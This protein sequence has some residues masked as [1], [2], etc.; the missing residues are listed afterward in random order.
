MTDK[1]ERA[2]ARRQRIKRQ[3]Q[4]SALT[5]L[6][7]LRMILGLSSA[8]L[9]RR[10]YEAYCKPRVLSRY[11]TARPPRWAN[12][13]AHAFYFVMNVQDTVE[14]RHFL[15]LLSGVTLP[16]QAPLLSLLTLNC[17]RE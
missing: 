15:P 7:L 10:A 17:V 11:F 4:L 9:E 2:R 6:W 1:P 14:Q 12:P 13:R 3:R 5:L 8:T 16:C